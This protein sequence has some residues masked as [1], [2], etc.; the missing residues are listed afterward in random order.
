VPGLLVFDAPKAQTKNFAP[1]IGV[2]YS[3][4]RSGATSIR[5]G[6]GMAYDIIYDNIGVLAVPPQ[7][8][9]FI[10]I[11]NMGLPNFLAGGGIVQSTRG[12]ILTAADARAQT[13]AWI[14]DQKLP[15][16]IQWNLA[17]QHVF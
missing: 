16:S 5:A 4:G 2:A 1:R 17:V 15:Y 8:S 10:D 14:P 12:D 13:S 9:T 3:P 7:F 6:F 11:A